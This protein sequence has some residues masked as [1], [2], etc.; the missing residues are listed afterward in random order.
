M[1][2]LREYLI[3]IARTGN[4]T[5]SYSKLVEQLNLYYDL[6]DPEDREDLVNDVLDVSIYEHQ[7]GRPL[8]SSLVIH[9]LSKNQGEGFF[10]IY[11]ELYNIDWEVTKGK[12]K[13]A[14]KEM[15][16]TRDFWKKEENFYKYRND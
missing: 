12:K 5:I 7:K 13:L 1:K 3:T 16:D 6:R 11:G 4:I 15:K 8:L 9:K 10:K 2:E 14:D